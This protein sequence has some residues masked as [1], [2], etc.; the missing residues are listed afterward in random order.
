MPK[1]ENI[2]PPKTGERRN[3]NGRPKRVITNLMEYIRE[4]YGI[5]PGKAEIR[6][7]MEYIESLP[8]KKLK[9]FIKDEN[10]PANVV[11]YGELILTGKQSAYRKVQG[12]EILNDRLNGKVSTKVDLQSTES[13]RKTIDQL[14][15]PDEEIMRGVE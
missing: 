13:L 6:S 3:P 5:T 4:T 2:R 9:L 12:S 15:P 14:F 11:A 8:I 10:V 1:P 7:L